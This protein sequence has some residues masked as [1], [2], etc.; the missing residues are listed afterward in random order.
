[1]A[2]FAVMGAESVEY[3]EQTVLGRADDHP[4]QALDYYGSRGETPLRWGGAGAARLGLHGEVTPEAYRLAFG[5]GGFRD[6]L[7]GQQLVRTTRPGF[8]LVVSAHKSLSLL[9]VVG[10][11]DDMHTILDAETSGTMDYLGTWM[12]A[13]GGRRGRAA[14][15]TPTSGLVYAVTR[16]ATSRLGDPALHDHVLIAN[17]CEMLDAK[18]GHKALYSAVVRD[19]AEAAAMAGRIR[20]AARAVELGYAIELD[21]G[22]SGRARDWRIAGIPAEACEIFSKRSDQIADYLAERGYTGYRARNVAARHSRPVKRGTGVEEL[23]PRWIGELEAHG[24]S[25]ERVAASLDLARQ[26]CVGLARPLSDP[27]IHRLATDLL[28]PQGAFMARCKVFDRARLVAEI[29]PRLYGHHPRELDRVVDRILASELVVPL[30]GIGRVREQPYASAAVLATEHTIADTIERLIDQPGPA[31]DRG[32]AERVIGAK[33]VVINNFLSAGQRQTVA[34]ICSSGRAVDVVVGVAGSG[35]TTALEVAGSAYETAGYRVLGTATSGQA[36]RTLGHESGMPARTMRSLLH[37]LDHGQLTLDPRTIVVLDEA[38][39]TADADLARLVLSVER[40]GSKL[41]IVGDPRQLSAV[42]PGGALHAALE[43]HPEIVTTLRANLRQRDPAERVAL[44]H[45]RDGDLETAID[46]YAT[47][48]RVHIAPTRVEALAAMVDAWAADTAAGHD[49]LM[50]SWRRASVA[51]LNRLAR[52]R[53]E[54]LGWLTGPDLVTR[55]GR[56][57][58]V[59]DLIVTLAPNPRGELVTSQRGRVVATDQQ[60][61]TLTMHTDDGRRV[62][63]T[64]AEIDKDHLDHGYALTV[65]R[66]QGDTADRTHCLAEGG[67]R[68]LAYV[69]MSRARGPSIVHAVADNLDQA[70]EDITYD[71]SLERNQRWISRTAQPGIDPALRLLPTDPAAK[72]ARLVA[73]L[74]AMDRLGPPRVRA[75]LTAARQDLDRLRR[76]AQDLDRGTGR[77]AHTP[78]GRAARQ[79]DQARQE[80]RTAERRAQL[81]EGRRERHHWRRLVRVASS[82]EARAQQDWITHTAPVAEGLDRGIT[83]AEHRVAD[84]EGQ[85]AFRGRWLEQHPDLGRRVEH[86]QRE[87]QRLDNPISAELLDRL[88]AIGRSP[89]PAATRAMEHDD[90]AKVRERLD[91]L[92]RARSIAPPPGLSL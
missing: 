80:R 77:W 16:H 17:V 74:A 57:Y 86:V 82:A 8:E 84:L 59:G 22:E 29:A 48:R 21:P 31:L 49:T 90:T 18:G 92:Q 78:A 43:R 20:S 52:V 32:L 66:E 33:Q 30:I 25:V 70:I 61:Q 6:P 40:A 51:D 1:M 91:R 63:L 47:N 81:A 64:G 44:D 62:V 11:A 58:A 83:T 2:W 71:W 37:R 60:A 53:A 50:L 65:H 67:G 39:M 3:H 10:R 68:E 76:S 85:A 28:D 89:A 69:A 38:S 36:T 5:P 56:G 35:K 55:D 12:Q 88:D 41:V 23:M 34:R 26:R 24:W 42:G 87:L 27:Q 13:R 45:L 72:R 73:E 19:M 7:T 15:A 75:D 14:T 79:L 46:F 9:G 4:G 54:Q